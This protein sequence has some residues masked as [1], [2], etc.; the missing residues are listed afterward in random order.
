MSIKYSNDITGSRTSDIP[1]SGA[2]RQPTGP[3]RAPRYTSNLYLL[4][5]RLDS[6]AV[7][8]QLMDTE[9]YQTPI[10]QQAASHITKLFQHLV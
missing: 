8:Q 1:A 9:N 4:N 7:C 6:Q 10:V 2:V 5:K 3:P